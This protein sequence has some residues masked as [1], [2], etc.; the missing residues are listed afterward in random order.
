MSVSL[1]VN[2]CLCACVCASVCVGG[3]VREGGFVLGRPVRTHPH[4]HTPTCA[5]THTHTHPRSLPPRP[6]LQGHLPRVRAGRRASSTTPDR[7]RPRR[8]TPRFRSRTGGRA[9][10]ARRHDDTLPSSAR[11]R[12]PKAS[13]QVHRRSTQVRRR[14]AP[15]PESACLRRD[16]PCARVPQS[17]VGSAPPVAEELTG[18][19]SRRRW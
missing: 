8:R 15:R 3:C 13:A 16:V 5:H 18:S 7:R 1:C 17:G 10:A 4:A 19:A 14:A 9:H 12:L 6:S 11:G 2:T